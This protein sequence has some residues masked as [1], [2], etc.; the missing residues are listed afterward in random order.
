MNR[1]IADAVKAGSCFLGIELGSTRIK[2]VL[3]DAQLIP[4]A[5][6]SF[7][8]SD[9]LEDG[10][11]TYDLDD[12]MKGVSAAYMGMKKDLKE[13]CGEVPKTLAGV[14]ISAMMHGYIARDKAGKLLVPFRTWRNTI[15]AQ[16]AEELTRLFNFNIPQRWTIA[17]L[18][19]A[20]LNNEPHLDYLD[21]VT[22]LEGYVHEMLTG[23]RVL[24]IDEASGLMPLA[25][26]ATAENAKYDPDMAEKFRKL[27]AEKGR[28]MD[29]YKL[30]PRIVPCGE[31]AGR[32]TEKGAAMLDPEGDL[33]PGVPFCPPE[34]DAGTG[35][36][37][38][39]SVRPLTGNISAG[40][41]IFSMIVLDKPLSYPYPEIDVVCT[42][43]GKQVAMA[44]CNTCT[45]DLNAWMGMFKQLLKTFGAEP[46][47]NEL[48]TRLFKLAMTGEPDCGGTLSYNFFA[49]EPVMG[50]EKGCPM[51]MRVPGKELTLENFM[52][53]LL[54]SSIAGLRFGS[55]ILDKE[56]VKVTKLTAHGGLL[57]TPGVVQKLLA[58]A[59]KTKI[60]VL[61]TAGEGG[62]WGMA[63]LAGYMGRKDRSKSLED[64]VDEAVLATGEA[65][66]EEPE[67]DIARG[68]DEYMKQY[69]A[70][71]PA[72]IAAADVLAK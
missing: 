20:L 48:Y 2:A 16:A 8:W 21:N 64:F 44:H 27:T 61:T 36:V 14:G 43:A 28:E 11:W 47:S 17:H 66:I 71:L 9:R 49:G 10:I 24:G 30:F 35:M 52:R 3:T 53:S 32:L 25:P 6:G 54:I 65:I 41:S 4:I 34:G 38:T 29:I 68:I 60:A 46:D 39:A 33:K 58:A 57:T 45:S 7:T 5:Q 31:V 26:N 70:L 22:A 42:P 37:A 72:Q 12:A 19:Q 50:L 1:Q 55:D 63:V 15:T 67:E 59:L 62:P 23:E 69:R 40:T 13:K 56:S 51:T 18:Y